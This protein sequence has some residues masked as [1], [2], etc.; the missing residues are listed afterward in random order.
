MSTSAAVEIESLVK[1]Y[2]RV[3]AVD[4]LS[5]TIPSGTITSVL[6]PNGAG[7]TTTI[8]CCEGYRRPD[9]GTVR[10]LGLDPQRDARRLRPRVG[11]MLQEGA[12]FYPG[13]RGVELLSHLARL[14]ATPLDVATL[15]EQLELG[16][17]ARTPMRRLSG[18]QRQRV[19][20]AA[21]LVGRPELV[22]LDE[23]TAG[24]DPRMRRSVWDTL[25]ELRAAGVTVVL[26]THLIEEAERLADHVVI[27]HDGQQVAQGSPAEL[28]EDDESTVRFNGRPRLDLASLRDA[29]P[30]DASVQEVS[31]GTYVVATTVD[32]GVLATITS[33]C[34]AHDVMPE[35][36]Q[37]GR[38]SLE[39]VFIKLTG[40]E[41]GTGS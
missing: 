7:K 35:G 30:E 36:L 20:L 11:V 23:P 33:W 3:P 14:H 5:L 22:F 19:A 39:D 26:C 32:P 31:P 24:L 27:I 10:V 41:P 40:A 25:S 28:T 9:S 34:A 6:G 38:T 4:G 13:A 1:C 18:G 37:V 15:V 16:D 2:G 29:L 8:E 12:G 17:T 21:A